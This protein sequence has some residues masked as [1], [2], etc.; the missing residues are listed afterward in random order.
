MG[1]WLLPLIG[2][3][4]QLLSGQD[5]A[6]KAKQALP[7]QILANRAQRM[8]INNAPFQVQQQLRNI[9]NSQNPINYVT[10][11]MQLVDA[12][13]RSGGPSE[14]AKEELAELQKQKVEGFRTRPMRSY[15]F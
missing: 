7:A 4:A 10:P 15:E 14:T 3:G 2:L 1:P 11:I 13:G 6:R 9:D 12:M 8:G 5:E